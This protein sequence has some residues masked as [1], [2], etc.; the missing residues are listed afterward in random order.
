MQLF[1]DV[2]SSLSPPHGW[3]ESETTAE[4]ASED[5]MVLYGTRRGSGGALALQ[6]GVISF[7]FPQFYQLALGKI[8]SCNFAVNTHKQAVWILTTPQLISL[9]RFC[10][11]HSLLHV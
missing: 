10:F 2:D 1:I 5:E 4:P 11:S 3:S 9:L 8:N 7:S 6:P